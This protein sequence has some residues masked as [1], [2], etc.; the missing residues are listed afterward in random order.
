MKR[1]D[2]ADDPRRRLLIK[3]LAAGFFSAG[4]R[5]KRVQAADMLGRRPDGL[6]PGRSMY[7]VSGVVRVN[8]VVADLSTPVGANDTVETGNNSEAIF[9]VGENAYILRSNSH[10]ELEAS[11]EDSLIVSA[12]RALTGAILAVSPAGRRH[13]VRTYVTTIGI[14]GTGYYLESDPEKT[15]FCTCYGVSDVTANGDPESKETVVSEHHDKPLYILAGAQ[16]GQSIRQAPFMNHT[17]QE[18][19][20]I[21]ALVGREPPF[22][23]P[24]DTYNAPRRNY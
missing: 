8:G 15:Y 22:V 17:D 14:R 7:R 10:I 11:Q 1:I 16:P 2:D 3:A 5:S 9:V 21:E 19:M 13:T 23:F 4:L 24:G 12:M 6:P 20:L 18:L